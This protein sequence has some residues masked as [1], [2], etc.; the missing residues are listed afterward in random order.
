VFRVDLSIE[1]FEKTRRGRPLKPL[2]ALNEFRV[3]YDGSGRCASDARP[4]KS[5]TRLVVVGGGQHDRPKTQASTRRSR[6]LSPVK[7]CGAAVR[8]AARGK[9]TTTT[10][11]TTMMTTTTTT[12]TVTKSSTMCAPQSCAPPV[13][14]RRPLH[15]SAGGARTDKH[16]PDTT[17]AVR[18]RP[19]RRTKDVGSPAS[20]SKDA[21]STADDG[22]KSAIQSEST[23][24]RAAPTRPARQHGTIVKEPLAAKKRAALVDCTEDNP[25]GLPSRGS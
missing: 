15:G 4:A 21:G 10:T 5:P 13:R 6:S 23:R 17:S 18:L 14:E 2:Q 1:C 12:T 9:T 22:A 11:T 20:E 24:G 25:A 7:D 19:G 16:G 8:D 3:I